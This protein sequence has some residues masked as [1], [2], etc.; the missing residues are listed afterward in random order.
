M[1]ELSVSRATIFNTKK[2]LIQFG[3]VRR[4]KG[5]G[6]TPT[7]TTPR[8][9]ANVKAR[10]RRN[11]IGPWDTWPR[12]WMLVNFPSEKTRLE[13]SHCPGPKDFY[14]P[15]VS[16]HSRWKEEKTFFSSQEKVTC[17]P[18][19]R[20][21]VFCC[22]SGPEQQDIQV[23]HKVEGQGCPWS[24]QEPFRNPNIPPS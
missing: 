8:L 13:P 3:H 10:I 18:F 17:H 9:L 20:R 16:R 11:P 14:L 2:C 23:H 4:K 21:E 15:P 22:W 6:G 5:F 7:V 1:A 12:S 19:H 24:H